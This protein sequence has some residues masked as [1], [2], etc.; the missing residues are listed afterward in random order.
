VYDNPHLR[1]VLP[2]TAKR[3]PAT[4][5]RAP[6]VVVFG[7]A[8]RLLDLQ[9]LRPLFHRMFG[10]GAVVDEWCDETILYS[11]TVPLADTQR[12]SGRGGRSG[13]PRGMDFPEEPVDVGTQR[14][15]LVVQ[16]FRGRQSLRCRRPGVDGGLA[17]STDACR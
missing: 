15:G 11:E 14:L 3:F 5:D 12:L 10:D 2:T 1:Y 7:I 13:L 16:L 4:L 17:D 6:S 8:E 9:A